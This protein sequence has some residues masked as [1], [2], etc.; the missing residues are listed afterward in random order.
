MYR[1][2]G[3]FSIP[4]SHGP[5]SLNEYLVHRSKVGAVVLGK[6]N[7]QLISFIMHHSDL[8]RNTFTFS[9]NRHLKSYKSAT[10]LYGVFFSG[11]C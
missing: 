10:F 11:Q 1:S 6:V 5:P 3:Q 7:S 9:F 8:K 2:V 4:H